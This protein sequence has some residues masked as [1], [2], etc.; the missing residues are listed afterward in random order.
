MRVSDFTI[1]RINQYESGIE[2]LDASVK[3]IWLT[4]KAATSTLNRQDRTSPLPSARTVMR[5]ASATAKPFTAMN[6]ASTK[7]FL[8]PGGQQVAFYRMDQRMVHDYP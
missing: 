5:S 1:T 2:A 4:A 6:L 7:V 3:V 8:G